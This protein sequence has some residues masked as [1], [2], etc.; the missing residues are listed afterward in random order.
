[1]GNK[2]PEDLKGKTVIVIDD[3][4]A[5]GN[6]LLITVNILKKKK[7]AKIIIA[8]PVA[9]Y[10]AIRKLRKE[11]DEV[12]S[13]IVPEQFYGLGAFYQDFEQVDDDEVIY[14]LERLRNGMKK[15]S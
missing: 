9:S 3:G 14:Y 10:N 7:P 15:V 12:I 2:E 8:V 11:V 1:M 5:T 13:V 4:I 6:T